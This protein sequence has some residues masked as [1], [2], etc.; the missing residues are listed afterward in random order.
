MEG[1]SITAT[2]VTTQLTA[3]DYVHLHNHTHHSLLDGLTKVNELV[4][5]VKNMGMEAVAVTDH[6]TMSGA[7]EFYKAGKEAGIKPIIGMEAYV[8]ARSRH[9][10]DPA[11]DKARYHLIILA[12]NEVGYQNLM[13]LSTAAHLEGMYYKPRIDHELLETYNE[14]LIILSACASGELGEKLRLDDYEGAKQVAS[15]YKSVFGDRY[16]LELQD[17]GHPDCPAKWDVQ[18]G[19]N[20]GLEKLSQELDIPCV[21]TSD[22]HYISHADQDAHEILLCVGTGAFLSDEK[23]MSLK[24]FEL[25]VTDPM[26][27]INRWSDTNLQAIANTRAIADRCNVELELGRILIPTFPVP[28]GETEKT[29]LD[30]LVY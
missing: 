9:D 8:A 10:R 12:M 23:R 4:D 15:W 6:G 25:H 20:K 17:H 19:I 22:G 29:F 21:I 24:D 27:I 5:V 7:V 2:A 11:K 3:A 13:R 14:G 28:S 16:Y 30:T 26:E 1:K 18:V